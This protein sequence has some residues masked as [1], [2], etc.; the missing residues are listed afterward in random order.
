MD[1]AYLYGSD[2]VWDDLIYLSNGS[3]SCLSC[4]G[5]PHASVVVLFE[6]KVR[7]HPDAYTACCF[8][9][10]SYKAF[11]NIDL[12]SQIWPEVFV[13][14]SFKCEQCRLHFCCVKL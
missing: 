12:L 9:V 10:E 2:A 5:F 8:F 7:I 6:R 13:V 14:A 4:P 11:S 3:E 1:A